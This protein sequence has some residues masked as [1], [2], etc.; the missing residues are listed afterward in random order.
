[1]DGPRVRVRPQTALALNN[2]NNNSSSLQPQLA[3]QWVSK[4]KLSP[5]I[6]IFSSNSQLSYP[7]WLLPNLDVGNE[8]ASS[9]V[10]NEVRISILT[11][12]FG[13]P[14][15]LL[16]R[17]WV[18]LNSFFLGWYRVS[19][20]LGSPFCFFRVGEIRFRWAC[21]RNVNIIAMR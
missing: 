11:A 3:S 20:N 12:F 2:N 9:F 19:W 13:F 5:F 15:G 10:R 17:R 18:Y 4:L 16:F 1:M 21:V 8:Y 6:R 14:L 7:V